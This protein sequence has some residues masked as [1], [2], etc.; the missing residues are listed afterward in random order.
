MI[1]FY[2]KWLE[3]QCVNNTNRRPL[4]DSS[5]RT[6]GNNGVP[7]FSELKIYN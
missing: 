3:A 6:G 4:S 1:T 5:R 7:E 2:V